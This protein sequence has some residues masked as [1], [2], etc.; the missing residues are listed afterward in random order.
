MEGKHNNGK[1][2]GYRPVNRESYER[3]YR[4]IYGDKEIKIWIPDPDDDPRQK[5]KKERDKS[6]E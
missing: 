5:P 6:N 1:G 2:D 4:E 3:N